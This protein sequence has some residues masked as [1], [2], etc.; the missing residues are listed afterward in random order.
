M[1]SAVRRRLYPARAVEG[2]AQNDGMPL[3]RPGADRRPVGSGN[4]LGVGEAR[5]WS[6]WSSA[7]GMDHLVDR[8]RFGAAFASAV[9]AA[10]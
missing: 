8:L 3:T 6:A 7:N 10:P 2:V 1:A 4:C 9:G 5:A